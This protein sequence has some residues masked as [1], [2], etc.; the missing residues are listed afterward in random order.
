MLPRRRQRELAKSLSGS[1]VPPNSSNVVGTSATS[2]TEVVTAGD[3]EDNKNTCI[4]TKKCNNLTKI[5]QS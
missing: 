2:T 4:S 3:D 1:L 5:I